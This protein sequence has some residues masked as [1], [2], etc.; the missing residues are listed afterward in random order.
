MPEANAIVR[1]R[2]FIAPD[3][4][5]EGSSALAP[6]GALAKAFIGVRNN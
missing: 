5:V 2:V 3:A 4:L 1:A 6:L